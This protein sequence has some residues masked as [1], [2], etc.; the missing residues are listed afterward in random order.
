MRIRTLAMIFA[1]ALVVSLA[2]CLST[3]GPMSD[4]VPTPTTTLGP[5]EQQQMATDCLDLW[6]N[7]EAPQSVLDAGVAP[8]DQAGNTFDHPALTLDKDGLYH[9]HPGSASFQNWVGYNHTAW[10]EIT[11]AMSG[12][13]GCPY[14]PV[15]K[16]KIE[17]AEQDCLTNWANDDPQQAAIDAG[18][19]TTLPDGTS[20]Q[21][22][23]IRNASGAYQVDITV[24]S[25]QT[26][27]D[28]TDYYV[29]WTQI[30]SDT[31]HGRGCTFVAPDRPISTPS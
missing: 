20:V 4:G 29:P 21:P 13:W 27:V 31:I 9:S 8:I 7:T 3:C 15:V 12:G 6:L 30:I 5:D 2:V 25:F 11:D 26:W 19:A 28:S 16:T 10:S 17:R 14:D 18:L 22:V 24:D 1:T 23:I